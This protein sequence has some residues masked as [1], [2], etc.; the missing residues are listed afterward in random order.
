[1]LH[2]KRSSLILDGVRELTV[3]AIQCPIMP[4]PKLYKTLA[5]KKEAN[6]VKSLK[7]Y[8]KYVGACATL[9]LLIFGAGI[10]RLS[11]RDALLLVTAIHE[12]F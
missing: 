9:S 6:R 3:A 7:S 1:M 8:H 4:R 11:L 5:S 2:A 10:E 12:F